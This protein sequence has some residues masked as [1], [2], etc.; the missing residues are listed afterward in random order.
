MN[1]IGEVWI[2]FRPYLIKILVD[3]LVTGSLW[4]VLFIFKLLTAFLPITDLAG[5][6]VISLHSAGIVA[7]V[8]IFIFFSVNDIIQIHGGKLECLIW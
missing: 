5:E 6:M 2:G 1:F 7:A 3:F 8:G 4:L